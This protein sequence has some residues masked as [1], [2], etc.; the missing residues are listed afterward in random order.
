MKLVLDVSA[1]AKPRRTGIGHYVARLAEA[2]L[3]A[4]PT[5]A[6]TLGI[7]LGRWRR[8]AHAWTPDARF[9]DR[10]TMRW[11]PSSWP[12]LGL[13]DA[14]VAHG[15]DERIVGG[16]AP[17]VVTIHDLFS[18]KS[19]AWSDAEFR[20]MK[21]A[22]HAATVARAAR[23]VVPSA[24]TARDVETLLRVPA[25]RISVTPLGVD[26][27]FHRVPEEVAR[28]VLARLGVR[29]PFVLFVGLAQPRK[30]LESIVTVFARLAARIDDLSLV[31]AGSDGYPEGR[32]TALIKETGAVERVKVLGYTDADDL[33]ALYSAASLL[34]FPSRDEGFG[35]P[36]LEAM[37]CGCPAIVSDRGA[38][39]EVVGPGGFV[40]GA[41]AFDDLEDGCRRL[42]EDEDARR[43][44]IER[45]LL[46]AA[47]FP[48]SRTATATLAAYRAAIDARNAPAT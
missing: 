8:R 44:E 2:L 22:R 24:A 4:D 39:P 6:V 32:L 13:P 9:A 31:L 34:L 48:W 17:Q 1:A 11:F 45:G 46:R 20:A 30:N 41:D 29:P 27:S 3:V 40:F 5:L 25:E 43:A 47:E 12:S 26:A 19:D 21:L 38:L 35:M 36:V 10:V 15:P 42:L 33:P 28:P 16:K 7:R 37:A 23:I 14:D 18:L